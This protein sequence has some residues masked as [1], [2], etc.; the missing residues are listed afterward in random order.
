M[1]D[2]LIAGSACL[3]ACMQVLLTTTTPFRVVF[4]DMVMWAK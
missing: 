3:P 4:F 1:R 2:L